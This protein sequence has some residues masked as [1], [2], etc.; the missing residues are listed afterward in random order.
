MLHTHG[1]R[2][3][4]KFCRRTLC[5][6]G[7]DSKHAKATFKY[8]IDIVSLVPRLI[9]NVHRDMIIVREIMMTQMMTMVTVLAFGTDISVQTDSCCCCFCHRRCC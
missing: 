7:G 2:P 4:A 3:H 6:F 8:Y 5:R 1:M 9:V